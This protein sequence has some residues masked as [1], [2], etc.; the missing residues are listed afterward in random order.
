MR[1][2]QRYTRRMRRRLNRTISGLL[3]IALLCFM[4]MPALATEE[5]IAD[6]SGELTGTTSAGETSE[7]PQ[8]SANMQTADVIIGYV[9]AEGAPL[10]PVYCNEWD[11]I[12]VNQL[13]FESVVD[14]DEN[15][16]PVPMLADSGP[17]MEKPG[18]LNC[19]VESAF[20]TAMTSHPMMWCAVMKRFYRQDRQIHTMDGFN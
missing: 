6:L 5:G 14:L 18:Y 20:T 17:R 11:L 7:V 10:N 3:M 2:I 8:N 9:A 12:S 15:M 4:A 16:K 1:N 19:A 13:V